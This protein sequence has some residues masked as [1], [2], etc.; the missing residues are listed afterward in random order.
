V[1]L[2]ENGEYPWTEHVN[3][4][5]TLHIVKEEEEYPTY[6]KKKEG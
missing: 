2:E 4:K 6:N 3:N 5:E 1:A